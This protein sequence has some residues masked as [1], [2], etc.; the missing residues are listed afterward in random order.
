MHSKILLFM[1]FAVITESEPASAQSKPFSIVSM[2][3]DDK[4]LAGA[5]DVA[6]SGDFA[7]VPGKQQSLSIID[8]RDPKTP[9]IVW[10][11]N[12]AEIPDAETVLLVGDHLLLG[13]R[14]FLTLDL[15]DPR[16]P[17]ILKTISDRPRIDK[18]NGMTKVGDI[19]I[20]ANKS[21]YIAAFDVSDMT[22]PKLQGAFETADAFGIRKPHDID[23]FGEYIVVVDPVGFSPP[24]GLIAVVKIA[25][26]ERLLPVDQWELTGKTTGKALIGANRVQVSGRFAFVGGSYNPKWRGMA[27]NSEADPVTAN[28][29]VVDLSDP[30]KPNIV[31][32]LPF[33]DLSG[34]NGLTIAGNVVFCAGGQT[35]TAY[36]IA[37]PTKPVTIGSQSLPKYRKNAKRSDNYHDLIYRGGYLY[38]SAQIDNGLLILKVEDDRIR[39]L[40]DGS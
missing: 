33:P 14:D 11:K 26:N 15:K 29:T 13:T 8:I 20:S 28:M 18:I 35:I 21:G 39:K 12:D 32:S 1:F 27:E 40:A 17:V 9:E 4:A 16:N 2:T 22:I 37:D 7:I 30:S 38:V 19:V 23:H 24:A 31:A 25:E 5:H 34:P 6:L 3:R 36:D 10:S